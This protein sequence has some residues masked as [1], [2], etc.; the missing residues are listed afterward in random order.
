MSKSNY[1]LYNIESGLTIYN[2]IDAKEAAKLLHSL[3]EDK[4]I[5]KTYTFKT[6]YVE[7]GEMEFLESEQITVSGK[8]ELQAFALP[9][10]ENVYK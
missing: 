9:S 7:N 10:T 2:P 5:V 3:Q 8:V 6:Y 1:V 4:T